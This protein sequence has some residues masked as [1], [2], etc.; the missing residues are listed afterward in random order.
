MT[1]EEL[2]SKLDRSHFGMANEIRYMVKILIDKIEELEKEI[3][4][5]KYRY[6]ERTDIEE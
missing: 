3:K 6:Q 1:I 2:K 5:I 4:D